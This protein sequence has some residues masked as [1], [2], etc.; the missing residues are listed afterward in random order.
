MQS[1][2][3]K[4]TFRFAVIADPHHYAP[5]LGVGGAAYARREGSDQKCLK[6]TGAILDAVFQK[7]GDD[8]RLDAVLLAGDLTNNGERASHEEM[9]EKLVKLKEKKAVYVI[10]STH[11]WCSNGKNCRYVGDDILRDVETVPE[12]A[13]AQLYAPFGLQDALSSYRAAEGNVSYCVKLG[14]GLRLLALN[15]DHNGQGRAGFDPAHLQWIE[16]QLTAAREADDRVIAMEHHLVLMH[17]GAL[18]SGAQCIGGREEV[19]ERFARAGLGLLFTGHSHMQHIARYTAQNGVTLTEVNAGSITGYPAPILTV[20]ARGREITIHTEPLSSFTYQGAVLGQAELREHAAHLIT[21]PVTLA[22]H[23]TKN[24]VQRRF[25]PRIPYWLL[26]YGAKR[27]ERLTVGTVGRCLNFFTFGK[28]VNRHALKKTAAQPVLPVVTELF[29]ALLDGK[30]HFAPDAP[31]TRVV[32]DAVRTPR[33]V[34]RRL[35]LH[36]KKV[37]ALFEKAEELVEN[38]LSPPAPDNWDVTLTLP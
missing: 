28:A 18:V 13:L 8:P 31:I 33:K 35:R 7:L 36:P 17:A 25:S 10:T 22:A 1:P 34:L 38:L 4:S 21:G 30:P 11:D 15:D 19:A 32:L 5:C 3:E 20:E 14:D 6:E 24:E 9:L 26:H 2:K 16:E 37:T 23:G 12:N 29:L 27:L